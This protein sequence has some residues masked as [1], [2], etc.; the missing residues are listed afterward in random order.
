MSND[1]SIAIP[2]ITI[3]NPGQE[4]IPL[5]T[6]MNDFCKSNKISN[7]DKHS[8]LD[9]I[10]YFFNNRQNTKFTSDFN[11]D[12]RNYSSGGQN[13]YTTLVDSKYDDLYNCIQGNM[14]P[15]GFLE[16]P[17]RTTDKRNLITFFI[18]LKAKSVA[19][20]VLTKKEIL[21]SSGA[22]SHYETSYASYIIPE[23][24]QLQR[25]EYNVSIGVYEARDVIDV[26]ESVII[27]DRFDISGFPHPNTTQSE[28]DAGVDFLACVDSI[29]ANLI[30][31]YFKQEAYLPHIHFNTIRHIKNFCEICGKHESSAFAINIA[32]LSDYLMDLYVAED[33][34]D[35]CKYSLGFPFVALKQRD[36]LVNGGA[37]YKKMY[38]EYN[39]LS[40]SQKQMFDYIVQQKLAPQLGDSNCSVETILSSGKNYL[41][42]MVESYI[43]EIDKY[44]TTQSFDNHYYIELLD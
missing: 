18:D 17:C 31:K 42:N 30:K 2:E 9:R 27:V 22:I 38:N 44:K 26:A 19:A 35:I 40:P 39:R 8:Y 14:I 4:D 32:D 36:I 33:N 41:A 13:P 16:S 24:S 25:H 12:R 34:E 6:I 7:I 29:E 23:A 43:D 28:V 3:G 10:L 1:V 15:F 20:K 11:N 37:F 5:R 21:T